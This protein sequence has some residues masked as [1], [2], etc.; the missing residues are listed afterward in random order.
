MSA[1]EYQP[2]N[3]VISATVEKTRSKAE[4]YVRDPKKSERLLA[5][6]MKKAKAQE[7][8]QG[9]LAG[10]WQNLTALFRL[11]Q[12]Y[13]RHEYTDIP[14]GSIVMVAV[15]VVYFVSPIDII[16]DFI[17]VSGFIDD[18]AV[19]AF[20][21]KQVKTDLDKFVAWEADHK[22]SEPIQ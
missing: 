5:E 21:L 4:E 16:P 2:Q 10:L 3:T 19:I 8:N 13:I 12:A 15:A 22:I 20:V 9:P 1:D 7:K 18:A 6:A 14:W 17:P 11:L